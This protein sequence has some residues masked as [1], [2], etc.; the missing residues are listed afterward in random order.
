MIDDNIGLDGIGQA[1]A[2]VI[3]LRLFKYVITFIFLII[4][5]IRILICHKNDFKQISSKKKR[6][7]YKVITFFPTLIS[8]LIIFEIPISNMMYNL[9]YETGKNAYSVSYDNYKTAKDFEQ[10]LEKRG[11]IYNSEFD[12]SRLNK[13]YGF[14]NS[15]LSMYYY[16]KATLMPLFTKLD[17]FSDSKDYND[18]I[19]FNSNIKAPAYIYNTILYLY[20]KNESLQY[21]PISRYDGHDSVGDT[22]YPF[23]EDYYIEC[24]IVYVD[25]DIYAIIGVGQSYDIQDYFN[26]RR[27]DD[28]TIYTYPYNMILSE[29]G[30]ITTFFNNKYYPDGAIINRRGSFEM[31]PNNNE[32]IW[33][34][35][36]NIRKVDKLDVFTLNKIARE[37][38]DGILKESIDYHFDK[39][40][41]GN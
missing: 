41:N 1:L 20:D 15:S 39:K 32:R 7:L 24:K 23:F 18:V 36:Y 29:R 26:K 14:I 13:K 12:L 11:F 6:I 38:Q 19:T 5:P 33:T 21:A 4:N 25:N 31:T 27:E 17:Y 9:K 3:L 8:L 2:I 30:T 16:E 37:L 35:Y 22:N 40:N 28:N 10:E 34:E